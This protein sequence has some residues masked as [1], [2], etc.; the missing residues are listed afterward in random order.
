MYCAPCSISGDKE[1]IDYAPDLKMVANYA[2]GYNNID[3]AYCLE[4]GITVAN[5]PDP[6]TAPTANLALG[7]MIDTA[8]RITGMRPC[9]VL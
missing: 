5:T 6:V 1:L 4:K 7:L 3:V 2:V 9:C 8:R